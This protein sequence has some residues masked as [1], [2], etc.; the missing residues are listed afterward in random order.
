[1]LN[2]QASSS[3]AADVVEH[4]L[5]A[6]AVGRPELAQD[7]VGV[8]VEAVVEAGDVAHPVALRR[9]AGGADHLAGALDAGDLAGDRAGR[10]GGGG[11]D[12]GVALDGA[13]DVGHPEVRGQPGHA[14]QP[15]HVVRLRHVVG[16]RLEAVGRRRVD[17]DVVLPA[18][19]GVDELADLDAGA[20]DATTSPMPSASMTA[21][22]ATG[23]T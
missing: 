13:S 6:V 12:D 8:V 20:F 11:D 15:E 2:R 7:V 10:A 23:G 4:H 18:H 1:M 21:P 22:R 19:L 9:G 5:V 3:V 14:E 17:H 16:H